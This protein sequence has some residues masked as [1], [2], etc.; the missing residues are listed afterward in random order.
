MNT[1]GAGFTA[2]VVEAR[3]PTTRRAMARCGDARA[4]G[5]PAALSGP[6]LRQTEESER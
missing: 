1:K 2:T 3:R 4:R 6:C 5:L